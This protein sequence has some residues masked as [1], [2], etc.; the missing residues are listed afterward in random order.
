MPTNNDVN[1]YCSE[2]APLRKRKRGHA[3]GRK[4]VEREDSSSTTKLSKQLGSKRR[5]KEKRVREKQEQTVSEQAMAVGLSVSDDDASKFTFSYS[6]PSTSIASHFLA[7]TSRGGSVQA[8]PA[9]IEAYRDEL[10]EDGSDIRF[11][12][13]SPIFRA[14]DATTAAP[15]LGTSAANHSAVGQA[16]GVKKQNNRGRRG[17]QRARSST[18]EVS[19]RPF[20]FWRSSRS[21]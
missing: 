6:L 13:H 10:D 9:L 19:H 4:H 5:A 21:L 18:S 8:R 17:G 20:L 12:F 15:F 2:E 14:T 7:S 1:A 3:G 11:S 16:N